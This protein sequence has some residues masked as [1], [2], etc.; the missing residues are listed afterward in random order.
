MKI[1]A[2]RLTPDGA[3][4]EVELEASASGDH[5]HSMYREIGCD[6]VECVGLREDLDLWIDEEGKLKDGWE[7][8][9]AATALLQRH[10]IHDLVAATALLTGGA[11]E[12]GNT[13]GISDQTAGE[14]RRLLGGGKW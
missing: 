7:V 2:I 14:V 8:N 10:G 4:A 11:D 6:L 13:L 1:P 3:L 12:D 5:L 9:L